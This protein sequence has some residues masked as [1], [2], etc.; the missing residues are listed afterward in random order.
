[1][2]ALAR[3]AMRPDG[4]FLASFL[5]FVER[6]ARLSAQNSLV[7]TALKL[8]APGVPDLYQN[9]ELWDLSLFDPDRTMAAMDEFNRD[10]VV[11]AW[12]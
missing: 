11:H 6:V 3:E 2:R 5:P 12:S 7:H 10:P 4:G 1:M 8:T 9:C